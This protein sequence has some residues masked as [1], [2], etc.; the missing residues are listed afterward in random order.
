VRRGI[1]DI[2]RSTKNGQRRI[3]LEFV[4]DALV[5]VNYFYNVLKEV[6]ELFHNAFRGVVD[7]KG[8]GANDVNKEHCYLA[9]FAAELG[10]LIHR[11]LRNFSTDVAAEKIPSPLALMHTAHHFVEAGLQYTPLGAIVDIDFYVAFTA[12]H[13][14]DGILEFIYWIHH[15][16][17]G[18]GR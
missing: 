8:G 18:I 1:V 13:T 2:Q 3:A 12:T 17:G 10:A 9:V 11:A 16:H 14:V 5:A 15:A 7:S 6:I 4:D